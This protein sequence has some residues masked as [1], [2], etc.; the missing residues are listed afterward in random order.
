LKRIIIAVA[1]A[2]L[3]GGIASA[4][5][6]FSC[7]GAAITT[8]NCYTVSALPH[9]TTQLDWA[10]FGTSN[11]D[12]SQMFTHTQADG[13][14]IQAQAL[15]APGT[16]QGLQLASNY[17]RFFN[18]T[19][20]QNATGTPYSYNG[21]FDAPPNTGATSAIPPG[22]PGDS[23]LGL[24]LNGTSAGS[25]LLNFHTNVT[26]IGFRLASTTNLTFD[27][28]VSLYSGLNGGGNLVAQLNLTNSVGGTCP[29]LSLAVPVPC[30][31]AAL[32]AFLAQAPFKSIVI[33]TND[34]TGFHIGNVFYTSVPEPTSLILCG[35]GVA[36]LWA[37]K[38]RRQR[39]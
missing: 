3:A 19:T 33:S 14:V 29:G 23:L 9:F 17:A 22:T 1:L 36:L 27:G 31:D 13:V 16:Q 5:S 35:C 11:G 26:D 8:N 21:R 30:N 4:S 39:S 37:G 7:G 20:W 12:F 25:L 32:V 10:A 6:A 15:N 18:G 2:S 24:G 28:V 34:T 38:K